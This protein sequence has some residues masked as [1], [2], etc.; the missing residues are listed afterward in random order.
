MSDNCM[1]MAFFVDPGVHLRFFEVFV[2]IHN[3][4]AL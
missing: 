3:Y 2:V 4:A 1:I